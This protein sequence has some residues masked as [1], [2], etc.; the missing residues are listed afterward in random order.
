VPDLAAELGVMAGY[1]HPQVR[2]LR[3]RRTS[4]HNFGLKESAV[5]LSKT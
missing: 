4:S 2:V 1:N 5:V 3:T